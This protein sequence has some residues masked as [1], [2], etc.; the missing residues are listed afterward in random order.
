MFL[1]DTHADT[2]Y[3][4]GVNNNPCPIINKERL[5]KGGVTLQVLALWTGGDGNRGD[6]DSIIKKELEAFKLLLA[7]G[8]IQVSSPL[9]QREGQIS[10][11]LSIEGCEM[12]EKS[13]HAVEEY[14]RMGVGMAALVWN[15]ENALAF[16]AKMQT[17]DGI[18]AYGLKVVKEMQRLHMAV[19]TSHLNDQGFFDLFQKTHL[20]P[21]ASH[22]NCRRLRNH[23][24]N[25]TDEQIRL[26]I[27]N[28]GYMGIN[29]YPYFLAE[30]E[31]TIETIAEHIDHVCQLG[32][33]KVVGFGSDYD[34]G[35]S[36]L[37]KGIETPADFPNLLVLLKHRGYSQAAIEGIAGQNLIDYFKRIS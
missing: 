37:P 32:G 14:A 25:L 10:L 15:N 35:F 16:P 3:E 7:Q 12:F 11:M 28:G 27:Q 18:T 24:R 2:L 6:V 8:M 1:C 20:P 26:L 23:F 36:I 34:G 13:L 21:C 4:M 19:D 17:N 9:E 29:F 30:G 31:T 22:S 33:E 5:L